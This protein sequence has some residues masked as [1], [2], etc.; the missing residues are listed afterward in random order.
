[1]KKPTSVSGE[2]IIVCVPGIKPIF[3]PPKIKTKGKTLIFVGDKQFN[4]HREAQRYVRAN[5][6]KKNGK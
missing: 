6:E 2:A 3:Y 4:T 5:H 1:M